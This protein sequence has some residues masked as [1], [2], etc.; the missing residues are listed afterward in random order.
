MSRK[1]MH[2][3]PKAIL[4]VWLLLAVPSLGEVLVSELASDP[5]AEGWTVVGQWGELA[6]WVENGVYYQ[7]FPNNCVPGPVCANQ[8]LSRSIEM[9]NGRQSWFYEYRVSGTGNQAEIPNGAPTVLATAN[10]FGN[11]YHVTL[12]SDKIKLSGGPSIPILFYDIEPAI[13]TIRLE[14]SNEPP[15]ATF[16]WYV[17]SVLVLEGLAKSPFPDFDS[18]ITWQG[19]SWQQ[20][21][22][23]AWHYIRAG[24]IPLDAS[25][26]FDS[27][28]QVD[29]FDHFYFSECKERSAGGEPVFPS[30]S[31]ADFDASG[32]VDCSD[33]AA[34]KAAWTGSGS[35]PINVACGEG[36]IPA[37]SEWGV[38]VLM[39]MILSTATI[40]F[41][42]HDHRMT[43][44]GQ[45]RA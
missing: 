37:V 12:A 35:P 36:A 4:T 39:L 18:R 43:T 26:D 25:G 45:R 31:W 30:C 7:D 20:P 38:V 17:D 42:V 9:F 32:T 5:L 11:A 10:S 3:R 34:F 19:R 40:L 8:S 41:R 2:V 16:H 24:D 13:H 6:S 27:N 15:P 14:L 23:N 21:T 29:S 22:V 28:G 33:W 1:T 44:I